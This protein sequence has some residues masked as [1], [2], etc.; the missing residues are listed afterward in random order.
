LN[1]SSE[2]PK[3]DTLVA[4]LEAYCRARGLRIAPSGVVDA[5]VAAELV[6]RSP[7]TL[8]NWRALGRGPLYRRRGGRV[9][10]DMHHLAEHLLT[11]DEPPAD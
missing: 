9:E 2:D 8:A 4:Q 11:F 1:A 7:Q 6:G 10:Y 5:H 3:C